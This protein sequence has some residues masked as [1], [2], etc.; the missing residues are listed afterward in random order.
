MMIMTM[1]W[2]L[3][4]AGRWSGLCVDLD[5]M[6]WTAEGREG[7]SQAVPD[8]PSIMFIFG[9]IAKPNIVQLYNCCFA[10]GLCNVYCMIPSANNSGPKTSGF[11]FI[12]D[13][14]AKP[15]IV[16]SLGVCVMCMIP[17]ANNFLVSGLRHQIYHSFSLF[18]F[19]AYYKLIRDTVTKKNKI[20]W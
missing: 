20:I 14:I 12:F 19:P 8:T 7:W 9:D 6:A 2:H 11:M 3:G 5:H 1:C 4:P 16:V 10:G 18:S 13:D 17:S 15:T